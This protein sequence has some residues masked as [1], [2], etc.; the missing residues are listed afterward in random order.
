MATAS[1]LIFLA[2]K[3]PFVFNIHGDAQLISFNYC[4]DHIVYIS[5][6]SLTYKLPEAG[7]LF[8]SG[9]VTMHLVHRGTWIFL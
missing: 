7:I 4:F 6:V 2:P 3:V 8:Q 5:L 9:L 1:Y